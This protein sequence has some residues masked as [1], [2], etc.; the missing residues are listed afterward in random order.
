[1]TLLVIF[2]TIN[3]TK[4][5]SRNKGVL[6]NLWCFGVGAIGTLFGQ[7]D[8]D[9][10]NVAG[11]IKSC[12]PP[13]WGGTQGAEGEEN[14]GFSYIQNNNSIVKKILDL[15]VKFGC[16]WGH[17]LIDF[18][19]D[20]IV[21]KVCSFATAIIKVL[22]GRRFRRM[23]IQAHTV[24][25]MKLLIQR[26]LNK[27]WRS[28]NKRGIFDYIKK[29]ASSLIEPIL[30]KLKEAIIGLLEKIPIVKKIL[31]VF[32]CL[33]NLAQ[34]IAATVKKRI[35]GIFNAIK[36][37]MSGGFVGFIKV[38]IK[39]ICQW[40]TFKQAIKDLVDSFSNQGCKK[41]KMIGNFVGGLCAAIADGN[42]R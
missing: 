4:I 31:D 16:V 42:A 10:N 39:G 36:T 37:I 34:G 38:I 35:A 7:R 26:A 9:P 14:K 15:H 30:K 23:F 28:K 17:C 18:T 25:R 22:G 24:Y 11:P 21:S 6:K 1:L 27:V 33:K 5:L 41:W 29:A 8:L 19:V 32:K 20:G 12:L 3:S 13:E 40:Q 2:S